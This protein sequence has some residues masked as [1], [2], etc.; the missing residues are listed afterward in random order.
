MSSLFL[1]LQRSRED[2]RGLEKTPKGSLRA[3]L[4]SEGREGLEGSR[5]DDWAVDSRL[6]KVQEESL[7]GFT[8]P[9]WGVQG[10]ARGCAPGSAGFPGVE[11][12]LVQGNGWRGNVAN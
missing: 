6:H 10:G 4:L 2:H 11:A 12:D 8:D 1:T 9:L 3:H 5:C 7:R